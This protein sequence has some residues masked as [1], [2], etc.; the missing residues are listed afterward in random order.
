[1]SPRRAVLTGVAVVAAVLAVVLVGVRVLDRSEPSGSAA[2]GGTTVSTT[3]D[4]SPTGP[5]APASTT[6]DAGREP[7]TAQDTVGPVL[8]VPGY[9]GNRAGLLGLAARIEATGRE[10]QV[11]TLPGGGT[12]DL[13]E[14]MAVLD[15]AADAAIA[16]GAPSVDVV[17]YSAGGLVAGLWVARGDGADRARR[18]VS[19][20]SPLHGT[21]LAAQGSARFPDSCPA[22][23][24]QMVPGSPL[25]GELATA[26]VGE[27]VPWLSLWTTRDEVVTPP[28]SARLDGAVNVELQAV[29]ADSAVTHNQL[30]T[31]PLVNG[32]VLHALRP[33]PLTAPTAADCTTLRTLG[34]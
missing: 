20:G 34:G 30:P 11:L 19:L 25:L 22:A 32:L 17:G 10:A 33:G 8:L 3:V 31:D 7:R 13:G 18:V 9:G 23:C 28:E 5:A 21:L 29:C 15:S 24:R 6:A 26:E 27:L 14:Q 16:A 2:T 1:M 4:A 12:G